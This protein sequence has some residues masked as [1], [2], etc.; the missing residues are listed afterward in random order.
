MDDQNYERTNLDVSREELLKGAADCLG[1][2]CEVDLIDK[3]VAVSG[4]Y[5]LDGNLVSEGAGKGPSCNLGAIAEAIEHYCLQNEKRSDFCTYSSEFLLSQASLRK[6]GI[7]RSLSGFDGYIP[8]VEFTEVYG[9]EQVAIPKILVSPEEEVPTSLCELFLNRYSTNSGSAFGCTLNEALL[10]GVNEV[11]E[12]HVLSQVMLDSVGV[13]SGLTV[14]EL[15][16]GIVEEFFPS[17][18]FELRDVAR[19]YYVPNVFSSF[20]CLAIR[21]RQAG[22]FLLPQ[23]G[24]GCSQ[25]FSLALS[26]AI[27]ELRQVES[28][29][30]YDERLVDE[31]AIRIIE[32]SKRLEGLRLIFPPSARNSNEMPPLVSVDEQQ[33]ERQL[34]RVIESLKVHGHKVYYRIVREINEYSFV[35]QVYI[36][37]L[38]RFNLI[39]SGKWVAPQKALL[40]SFC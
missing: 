30:A 26:R 17:L 22:E 23:L 5:D 3:H 8:C 34:E 25:S 19:I 38:E 28:L 15:S 7:I 16:G 20:F 4:L 27:F 14:I 31:Q 39:R 6:D 2:R 1:F 10:H 18:D 37:G 36:P 11:I 9:E 29:Y 13:S 12:R 33:P 21:D 32:R 40:K 35:T 24:A